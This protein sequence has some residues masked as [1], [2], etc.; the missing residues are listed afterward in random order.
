MQDMRSLCAAKKN[1]F[2]LNNRIDFVDIFL[3]KFPCESSDWMSSGARNW[4]SILHRIFASTSNRT[5]IK[6]SNT[7]AITSSGGNQSLPDTT[8]E[9]QHTQKTLQHY[10]IFYFTIDGI[11]CV[12]YLS[13][14]RWRCSL[15]ANPTEGA[16]FLLF[17]A[18]T[19]AR[20]SSISVILFFRQNWAFA[21]RSGFRFGSLSEWNEI[22]ISNS[23]KTISLQRALYF[24]LKCTKLR[25]RF[26]SRWVRWRFSA[27]FS[28]SEWQYQSFVPRR[29]AQVCK[30]TTT[31]VFDGRVFDR[32]QSDIEDIANSIDLNIRKKRLR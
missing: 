23:S 14:N 7:D 30:S 28:H 1:S 20:S 19:S 18:H 9:T 8:H 31:C 10:F 6:G 3:V 27:R 21:F 26:F 2:E 12:L 13:F 17:A 24:H 29:R 16:F 25:C 11:R 4:I 32:S 22:G 15:P 5:K